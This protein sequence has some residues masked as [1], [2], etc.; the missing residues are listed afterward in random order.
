MQET[1]A[2]L[3]ALLLAGLSI[4]INTTAK[5]QITIKEPLNYGLL[6][7]K[8]HHSFFFADSKFPEYFILYII[9]F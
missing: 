5:T 8:S 2:P 1:G 6:T 4:L 3:M 7:N 9:I